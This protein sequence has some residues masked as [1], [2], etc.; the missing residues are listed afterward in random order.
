MNREEKTRRPWRH[1]W[2]SRAQR[3]VEKNKLN[4]RRNMTGSVSGKQRRCRENSSL[5]R[6]Q[7]IKTERGAEEVPRRLVAAGTPKKDGLCRVPPQAARR[8]SLVMGTARS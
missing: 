4:Y 5:S 7:T 3:A 1:Y 8:G 2:S 6:I